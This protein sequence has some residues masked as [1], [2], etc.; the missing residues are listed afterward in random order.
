[1]L[2]AIF[3]FQE[4]TKIVDDYQK[5]FLFQVMP[6]KVTYSTFLIRKSAK[7]CLAKTVP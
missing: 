5:F 7:E 2:I 6:E 4:T 1:M 3:C